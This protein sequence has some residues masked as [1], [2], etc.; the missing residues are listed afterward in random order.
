MARRT[1]LISM[2]SSVFLWA[3][4]FHIII[5]WKEGSIKDICSPTKVSWTGEGQGTLHLSRQ[6][7][8]QNLCYDCL[9]ENDLPW[10]SDIHRSTLYLCIILTLYRNTTGRSS[11]RLSKH[12]LHYSPGSLPLLWK[13]RSAVEGGS[14]SFQL[15]SDI[16]SNSPQIIKSPYLKDMNKDDSNHYGN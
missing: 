14:S 10:R 8:M 6:L 15:S 2:S 5:K 1:G 3:V 7:Q 13:V 12:T 16:W 9:I 11:P 4:W